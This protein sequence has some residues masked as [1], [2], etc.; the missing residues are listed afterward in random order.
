[1][2]DVKPGPLPDTTEIMGCVFA[3]EY[4]RL[5]CKDLPIGQWFRLAERTDG[6]I[7]IQTLRIPTTGK[8]GR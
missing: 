4:F 7:T 2:I 6:A 3:D 8:E 1:M 5:F